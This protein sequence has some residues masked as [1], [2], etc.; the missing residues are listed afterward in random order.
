MMLR[1]LDEL[2]GLG[3]YCEA[4][5]RFKVSDELGRILSAHWP[6]NKPKYW[7]PETTD[8]SV[9]MQN[10]FKSPM[11]VS[12]DDGNEFRDIRVFQPTGIEQ[13]FKGTSPD[14]LLANGKSVLN[15][16]PP[17]YYPAYDEEAL[18]FFPRNRSLYESYITKQDTF[19]RP[20]INMRGGSMK[21]KA[22]CFRREALTGGQFG[23]PEYRE[24]DGIRLRKLFYGIRR[25][26]TIDGEQVQ[27]NPKYNDGLEGS[28]YFY[29]QD[30]YIWQI[31]QS[32]LLSTRGDV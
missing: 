32:G 27:L 26:A 19:A 24:P 22:Y 20:A 23:G 12:R 4:Y 30:Q 29:E 10:E 9:K 18:H 8:D 7:E 5:A 25:I 21:G 11:M 31:Y 17:T 14:R 28:F 2:P 3:F 1:P 16:L 15:Y 6:N 13:T